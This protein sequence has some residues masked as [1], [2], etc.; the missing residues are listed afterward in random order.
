MLLWQ[1]SNSQLFHHGHSQD[2]YRQFYFEYFDNIIN[3]IKNRFLWDNFLIYEHI[4]ETLIKIFKNK[5]LR[6]TCRFLQWSMILTRLIWSSSIENLVAEIGKFYGLD[7]RVHLSDIIDL[8]FM[9]NWDQSSFETNKLLIKSKI[10]TDVLNFMED[11]D[12]FF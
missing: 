6:L 10:L 3:W 9:K 5:S 2:F 1:N 12:N 8:F 11:M 7:R 4:P